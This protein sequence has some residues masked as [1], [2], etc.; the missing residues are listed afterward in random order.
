M[1][2]HGDK[3]T[4]RAVEKSDL[5][6]LHQW[7][8]DPEIQFN[9]GQWHFPLSETAILQWFET[10]RHDGLDQRFVIDTIEYGP[11]GMTNLVNINWKDR[12]AFTGIMVGMPALRRKGFG[13]DAVRA[14]MRYAF[15]ELGLERLDTTIIAHNIASLGLYLGKCGWIEEGRK[16]RA[17][18]RRNQFHDNVILGI[19]R[20][21]YFKHTGRGQQP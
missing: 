10:F 1:N 20:D 9:L 18:F 17:F 5:A 8:N 11:I 12:N 6:A 3:I 15:E 13:A 21:R 4:L 7:A 14:T 16:A 19:T 2:V